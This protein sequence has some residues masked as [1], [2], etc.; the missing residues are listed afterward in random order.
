MREIFFPNSVA[1]IGVSAKPDNLGRNIVGNLVEYGFNG[2]VYAV[3]PSGGMIETRRIYKSVSD[4]PDH[5]D[6]AVIITPAKTVP[7]ILEQCGQK[8]VR[9]AIIETAGFREYGEEGKALESQL[10]SRRA[11]AWG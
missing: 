6:L 1:V 9:W 7:G 4:I 10:W 5:V 11:A 8:G 3:G 2:V